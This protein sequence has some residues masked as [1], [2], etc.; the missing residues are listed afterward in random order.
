[1]MYQKDLWARR[2][3]ENIVKA[4][5]MGVTFIDD[6][7][8]AAFA[9]K[10]LPMQQESAESSANLAQLIDRIRRLGNR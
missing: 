4:K 2:T 6:V 10:V 7:D 5:K 1:M 9:Q 8:K 3:R